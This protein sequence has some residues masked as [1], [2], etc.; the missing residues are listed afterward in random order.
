MFDLDAL[1]NMTAGKPVRRGSTSVLEATERM[2]DP[3]KASLFMAGLCRKGADGLADSAYRSAIRQGVKPEVAQAFSEAAVELVTLGED[4][5]EALER[6]GRTGLLE[7]RLSPDT[8]KLCLEHVQPLSRQ[9][10]ESANYEQMDRAPFAAHK[11]VR[12]AEKLFAGSCALWYEAVVELQRS[13]S[14][15]VEDEAGHLPNYEAVVGR[16]SQAMAEKTGFRLTS[17]KAAEIVSDLKLHALV[18]LT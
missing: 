16:W 5:I 6:Y 13:E 12:D 11:F 3:L 1:R 17:S 7:R 14:L 9:L 4:G 8:V 18:T 15:F 10:S 2:P